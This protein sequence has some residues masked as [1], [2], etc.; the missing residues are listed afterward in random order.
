MAV[1]DDSIVEDAL[2]RVL[3]RAYSDARQE[4]DGDKES[5]LYNK[6]CQDERI[7]RQALF[8]DKPKTGDAK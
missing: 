4:D 8:G 7:L 3:W 5:T 2:A 1:N 6:V